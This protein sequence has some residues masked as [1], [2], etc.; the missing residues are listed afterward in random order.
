MDPKEAVG[1]AAAHYV[2]DGMTIGI[3][4]G[5]TAAF[6]IQ[7]LG[8]RVQNEGLHLRAVPTSVRSEELARALS[9]PIISLTEAG[10]LDLTIDGA[11][12]VDP[13]LNLIKGAGGALLREKLVAASS[14]EFIVICDESKLKPALGVHPLPVA[15][16][17]FGVEAVHRQLRRFTENV[18]LRTL[19]SGSPFVTDDGLYIFDL[20]LERILDPAALER[21]LKQIVG[22]AEVGLFVHMT[23]RLLIGYADGHVEERLPAPRDA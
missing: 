7:A 5:S 1:R 11:D 21:N 4:T 6:L 8:E 2:R 18:V 12:D 22:V 9:I 17:P 16:I 19:S 10:E 13:A 15:V 14:H 23:S 3:G 20:H